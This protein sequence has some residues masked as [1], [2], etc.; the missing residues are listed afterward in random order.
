MAFSIVQK[1]VNTAD[2]VPV[3]SN[4][5]PMT[6]YMFY[7]SDISTFFFYRLVCTVKQVD[8]AG[9]VLKTLGVLKQRR[10]GYSPD[11]A[12]ATQR[13]RAFFDL[14]GIVNSQLVDTVYD[15]NDSGIP[16]RTI[17]KLGANTDDKIFSYN[18]DTSQGFLQI[19]SIEVEASEWYSDS[20][21]AMPESQGS[22]ATD[23]LIWLGASLPLMTERDNDGDYIQ[24]TAF[25]KYT[26]SSPGNSYLSDIPLQPNTEFSSSI[27]ILMNFVREDDFHTIAFLNDFSSFGSN[28]DYF[29]I[30][31]YITGGTTEILY[32]END[33]TNGGM[34][35]NDGSLEDTNRLLYFGCGPG[36]LEGASNLPAS[37][38]I[39]GATVDGAAQ[40]S[41]FDW[42]SYQIAPFNSSGISEGSPQYFILQGGSC[43]GYK[44]RRLAFRNSF[45]CWDYFNFN[46]K[47]T[48]TVE[49]NRNNYSTMLGTFNKSRWRYD[50]TQRGNT[51]RQTTAILKETLNTDWISE[52]LSPFIE[53]LIYSTNVQIVEN[54]DTEFTEGVIVTDSS[55]IRKTKANDRLIQYTITIEYANPINTNS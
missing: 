8:S 32:I 34:G 24:G 55:F 37:E 44:I 17:H 39:G 49:V 7:Q 13:A 38:S 48:Q 14:S 31:Y 27:S 12:G 3:I 10:N 23:T 41:N 6:G 54:S 35:S 40:P 33:T 28:V 20:A 30:T 42:T 53:K 19:I 15:Q 22:T 45:G 18:G 9:A 21:T 1:P 36:N 5:T 43:K 4:W 16:F 51:T 52:E 25:Q 50:N 47:S 11:N 26:N 2:N 29:K 46:M